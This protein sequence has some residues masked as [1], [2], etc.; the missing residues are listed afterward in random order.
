MNLSQFVECGVLNIG[1]CLLLRQLLHLPGGG[2][3]W[4]PLKITFDVRGRLWY[5]DGRSR[6]GLE[7]MS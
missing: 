7:P 2:T 6:R 5:N 3:L 1:L 4:K